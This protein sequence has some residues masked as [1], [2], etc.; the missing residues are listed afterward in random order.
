[1]KVRGANEKYLTIDACYVPI[2]N[3]H[4]GVTQII[5]SGIDVTERR[6]AELSLQRSEEQFRD[7][8][9]SAPLAYF[10]ASFDGYITRVNNRASELLGYSKKEIIG[11]PVLTLYAPTSEGHEKAEKIQK[12]A[13]KGVGVQDE[14]LEMIKKDGA[15]IWVSLTVRLIFDESGQ[16]IERRGMVQDI[17][18]RKRIENELRASEYRFRSL[19]ETAGSIIIG[20]RPDGWIV[21]WNR[22]AERIYGKSREEV[23][24]KNYLELFIPDSEQLQI[25]SNIN[26][27]LEGKALRDFQNPILTI[28]GEVREILWNVDRLMDEHNKPYGV[29]CI[30]RDITEWHHAQIQLKKWAT[31]YQHTQWGVA[32]GRCE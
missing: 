3:E 29:I 25:L 14:E 6:H 16:I 11:K 28:N 1:M 19:I 12:K 8:Y 26:K 27:V 13:Q 23:L 10:S 15:R 24:D 18:A 21:E 5:G 31:I 30:G 4:G 9:D 32:V 2:T 22:E 20:L 17:S 7:L